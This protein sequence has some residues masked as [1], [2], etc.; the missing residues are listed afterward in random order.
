MT[1]A[2]VDYIEIF[3][4]MLFLKLRWAYFHIC[5]W[6]VKFEIG[7]GEFHFQNMKKNS[8]HSKI[9]IEFTKDSAFYK[10]DK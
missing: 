6:Y 10:S 7:A 1:R 9:A 4:L 3:I 2:T 8:I 5:P